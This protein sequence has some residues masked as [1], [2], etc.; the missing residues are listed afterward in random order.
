MA[1]STIARREGAKAGRVLVLMM[2]A[3]RQSVW[4]RG[5]EVILERHLGDDVA[6]PAVGS[7]KACPIV[8]CA[9]DFAC[10]CAELRPGGEEEL[11]QL[12]DLEKG[13][14]KEGEDARTRSVS[15]PRRGRMVQSSRLVPQ[16]GPI[17]DASLTPASNCKV[18]G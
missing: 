7:C 14:H 16:Y 17:R 3:R 10:P 13:V 5:G 8:R 18:V 11:A 9:G 6:K 4:R 15:E 1:Q 2:R 12:A